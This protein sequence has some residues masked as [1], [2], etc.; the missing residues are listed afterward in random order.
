[1]TQRSSYTCSMY[2]DEMQLLC[3]K[4]RLTEESLSADERRDLESEIEALERRMGL[5]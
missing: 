4:R 1:M 2:R 3:L 5:D